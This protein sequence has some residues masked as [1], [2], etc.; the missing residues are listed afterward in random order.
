MACSASGG[1]MPLSFDNAK[2]FHAK[3]NLS[4]NNTLSDISQADWKLLSG[5]TGPVDPSLK[6]ISVEKDGNSITSEQYSNGTSRQFL[7][8]RDKTLI[9]IK[10]P[11]GST[12]E[13]V[14][15][16]DTWVSQ[17]K[18]F[19]SHVSLSEN[20]TFSYSHWQGDKPVSTEIS[21]FGLVNQ[22]VSDFT[23]NQLLEAYKHFQQRIDTN[24]DGYI[25]REELKRAGDSAKNDPHSNAEDSFRSFVSQLD[26]RYDELRNLSNNQ[27]PFLTAISAEDIEKS[28]Q[29]EQEAIQEERCWREVNSLLRRNSLQNVLNVSEK[30][31]QSQQQS[32][33][34]FTRA[35]REAI[36]FLRKQ[37]G[38]SGLTQDDIKQREK[39]FLSSQKYDLLTS[40]SPYFGVTA[41]AQRENQ[42]FPYKFVIPTITTLAVVDAAM[43]GLLAVSTPVTAATLGVIAVGGAV[44]WTGARRET[45]D[46]VADRRYDRWMRAQL[47]QPEV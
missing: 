31:I 34:E 37:A 21:P 9:S 30:S 33:P 46:D 16:S 44:L 22:P 45:Y 14:G 8:D 12:W 43:Y 20:G 35:D 11:D 40:S 39:T 32:E 47:D 41:E 25:T 24:G 4:D 5:K 10:H 36:A 29:L 6:V 38:K 26:Q 27:F 2:K 28:A 17:G 15:V 1:H 7:Y 3:D 13:R 18:T 19:A 42:F 23:G